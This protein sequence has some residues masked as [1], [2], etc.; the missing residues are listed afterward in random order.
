MCDHVVGRNHGEC[1]TL[2]TASVSPLR[3]SRRVFLVAL[4]SVVLSRLLGCPTSAADSSETNNNSSE[5]PLQPYVD[6]E[7]KFRLLRPSAWVQDRIIDS[8]QF[9]RRSGIGGGPG[10]AFTYLLDPTDNVSVFARP[11]AAGMSLRALGTPGSFGRR[12]MQSLSSAVPTNLRLATLLTARERSGCAV[13]SDSEAD[14]RYSGM[15]TDE[16]RDDVYYELEYQVSSPTWTRRSVCVATI[17]H[18]LIYTLNAQVD[19]TRWNQLCS[20]LRDIG[21]SFVVL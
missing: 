6:P 10:V 5:F 8:S 17:K 16:D 13:I 4:P 15:C 21:R 14:T 19:A 20:S 1:N 9:A 2:L 11:A 3:L 7:G 12:L 18:G